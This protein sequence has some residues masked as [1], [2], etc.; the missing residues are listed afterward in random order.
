MIKNICIFEDNNFSDLHPLTYL[1]PVYDLRCGILTLREKIQKFFPDANLV[2][3][4]RKHLEESVKENN[5]GIKVN[6]FDGAD[7]CLFIN[8]RAVFNEDLMKNRI[9][10]LKEKEAAIVGDTVIGFIADS[11][12]TGKLFS[13]NVITL[14]NFTGFEKIELAAKLINYP[15]ELVNNNANEIITDFDLLA[16]SKKTGINCE[17]S[18]NVSLINESNIFIDEG[19]IIK[20]GVVIDATE[21]P[22][23]IGKNVKIFP[24]AVIEGP[25]FVG[26]NS[27]IKIGAKIY[28]GSSIGEYCKVGGEVEKS[29]IH[30]FAN[31]QHDGFLGHSYI[32]P[33][34]NLGAAT[35]T[36]DLK[37]NYGNVK[38]FIN[39]RQVD[40]GSM[41]VG[42]IM[43]DHSKSAIN[44]RFNTGT[45]IGI[46]SNIFTS[47]FPPKY[48]PSFSWVDDKQI[49]TYD[50]A[51]SK[52]VAD[53]VM[54]RREK[55]FTETDSKL[56][57]YVYKL[58]SNERNW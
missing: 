22:V 37:N 3:H 24:N 56:F 54:Q 29:I 25:C 36:S 46:S 50:L 2:L 13:K 27:Q 44:T 12:I 32:S 49:T 15:W 55:K 34:C 42:L 53:K 18:N 9:S 31:K 26:N 11:K 16:D 52:L 8:G 40:T 28:D 57:D 51:K 17:L 35:N 23:Y 21:G 7:S 33:W 20:P 43:G 39:N 1:R 14:D 45:V 19:T 48:I 10:G 41:F 58:T 6:N 30:S 4:C 47:N 38:V 5:P